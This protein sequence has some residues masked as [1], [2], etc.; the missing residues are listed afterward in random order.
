MVAS[1]ILGIV[2]LSLLYSA[3]LLPHC[4]T[5]KPVELED[6]DFPRAIRYLFYGFSWR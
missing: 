5:G 4:A 1:G 6:F 3:F 2:V